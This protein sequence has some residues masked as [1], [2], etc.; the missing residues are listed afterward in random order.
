MVKST[1]LCPAK[2]TIKQTRYYDYAAVVVVVA[3]ANSVFRDNQIGQTPMC[4]S[5]LNV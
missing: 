3:V 2:L 4:F 5:A 1:A